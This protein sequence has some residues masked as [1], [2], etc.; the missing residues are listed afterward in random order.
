MGLKVGAITST[1]D[2]IEI[3]LYGPG[4]HTPGRT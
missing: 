3:R 1:A 4:G 2:L